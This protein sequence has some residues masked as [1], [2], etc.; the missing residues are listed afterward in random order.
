[1]TNKGSAE[2]DALSRER[3]NLAEQ[4]PQANT[5]FA[6]AHVIVLID[7]NGAVR[8]YWLDD[9]PGRGNSIN[10]ARLLAKEGPTP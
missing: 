8:G 1:M 7:Q 9:G 10:A 3:L 5:T 2:W 4:Y 6:K